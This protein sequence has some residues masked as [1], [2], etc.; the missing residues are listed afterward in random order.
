MINK[1]R[2][3]KTE[4]KRKTNKKN[5]KFIYFKVEENAQKNLNKFVFISVKTHFRDQN[6]YCW[7]TNLMNVSTL[8]NT[9]ILPPMPM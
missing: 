1:W 2:Q 6:A 5:I 4:T 3:Y 9:R 8:V 7:S